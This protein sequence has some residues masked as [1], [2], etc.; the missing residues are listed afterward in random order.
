LF[1]GIIQQSPG[2]VSAI[3]AVTINLATADVGSTISIATEG[4]TAD[5]ITIGNSNAATTMALT[6]GDDW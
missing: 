4:T 5:T 3:S 6:G 2:T 1:A